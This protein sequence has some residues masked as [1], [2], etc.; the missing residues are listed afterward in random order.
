MIT[1]IRKSV[2]AAAAVV[3]TLTLF[4]AVASLA[5]KDKAALVAAKSKPMQMAQVASR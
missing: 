1:L 3:T 5:D 4:S 2:A